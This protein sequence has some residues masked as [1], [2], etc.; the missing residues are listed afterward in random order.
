MQGLDIIND[1]PRGWINGKDQPKWHYVAYKMWISMWARCTCPTN[2]NYKYYKD[3]SIYSEF[4][5]L[6]NFILWLESEKDFISFVDN[7]KG[8]NIDKDIKFPDNRNYYPECMSLVTKTTN[9]KEQYSRN[10]SPIQGYLGNN[11][12]RNTHPFRWDNA[13]SLKRVPIIGISLEDNTILIFKSLFD[14]ES[15]GFS[16]SHISNCCKNKR[17]SHK[18]YRWD[19]LDFRDRS[20]L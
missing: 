20:D 9:S 7:P 10:G 5:Y 14:A 19:Y 8:W 17:K 18:G 11:H 3:C 6:S 13:I 2:K 12:P 15:M 4:K 1:M 16:T